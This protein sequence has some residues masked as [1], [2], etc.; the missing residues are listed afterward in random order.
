M[1]GP[2]LSEYDV[3]PMKLSFA[4]R[5][6]R[7]AL[8]VFCWGL[9][10]ALSLQ[11]ALI[12]RWLASDLEVLSDGGMVG[13]WTSSSG[14]RVANADLGRE[15]TLWHGVTPAGGSVVR[16]ADHRLYTAA[17][18]VG[19]L[20]AFS[21][22]IVF[23]AEGPGA[24]LG[25][26]W[27][28][29]SG[30]VDAEQAGYTADWGAVIDETGQ[31][32]FGI[33]DPDQ[34]AY[35]AD[36]ISLVDGEFHVAVF[37]WGGGTQTVYVDDRTPVSQTGSATFPRNNAGC[38]FGSLHTDLDG[39]R[40]SGELVEV[41]FYDSALT[42]PEAAA[43][44][45]Q[46]TATHIDA[47]L[48]FV[49]AF[50]AAPN[51][52]YV[53]SSATLSWNVANASGL[54][55]AP[56]VGTVSGPTGAVMVWPMTTT[57]YTLA[58]TNADGR[59]EATVTVTVDPGIPVAFG[60][61]TNTVENTTVAIT[62][63]GQDPNGDPLTYHLD[64][65]P[66]HGALLGT[67]PQITYA[68]AA[69][70]LGGDQLT[71]HVNDGRTDSSLAVV[72]VTVVEPPVA[73]TDMFLSAASIPAG[74]G[75]SEYV[76]TI[77]TVDV[78]LH[79]RHVYQLVPGARDNARFTVTSNQLWTAS[80]F[81]ATNG[82]S[83]TVRLRVTDSAALSLEKDFTLNVVG[84]SRDVVINEIHYNPADN[85]VRSEFIEF[86]NPNPEP[87]DMGG[88]RLRGGVDFNFPPGTQIA[89]HD[90]LVVAQD[91]LAISTV[92]GIAALG[93][94][95][96]SL[97]N[98]GEQIA[99]RDSG[100]RV[101]DQVDYRSEFPW[102]VAANGGGVSMELINPALDN[103]LGSSWSA[104]RSDTVTPT[105]L[106]TVFI[107][108]AD[109]YWHYRRGTNEP[110]S[111]ASAWRE[112]DFA[113]DATWTVGRTSIGYG[114]GDDNTVLSDMQNSYFCFFARHTFTLTEDPLPE[115]LVLRVYVDDGAILWING[116]EVA[117]PHVSS[118]DK[119]YNVGTGTTDHEAAW[120]TLTLANASAF[121]RPGENVLVA[122]V[123]NVTLGSSDVSFDLELKTPDVVIE[124]PQ[125]TPGQRNL[126]FQHNAAPNIRQVNH[127]PQSPRSTNDLFVT[128]K[129]T[130]PQGVGAVS[131]AY[132]S[133]AP[134]AFIPSVL[135]RSVTEMNNDPEGAPP[136]NPA[137][138]LGWMS[139]PMVDDGTGG[140]AVAG[141]DIF[142]G[143]IPAQPNRTLVRYRVTVTDRFGATRRAPFADDPSLNFAAF[144]YDGV[145]AYEGISAA[146]LETLPVYFFITRAQDLASCTAY[147]G[148]Q[149][150]QGSPAWFVFNW[151]CAV[152][153][154]GEVYDHVRYRLR[155]ANGR[156]QP[157]K[158][159]FRFKFNDGRHFAARDQ[160]GA[161]YPTKWSALETGKGQSNQQTLTFGLN[162][163]I[164]Y[165]LWNRVGVPAPFSHFFHWRVVDGAAEAPDRYGGDFWGLGWAQENYD[166]RFLEAHSLA[167]GNLYKLVNSTD[168]SLDQLRYQ[169]PDAV[170]DGSDHA[171]IYRNLNSSQTAAW[172]LAHV[173]YPLWYRYHA[174][175]EGVRNY[176]FWPGCDKN[177]AYYF[178]PIY[179]AQNDYYGRLWI[180]PWDVTDT[181][182]PTWNS[183]QDS[184][185]A[186]IFSGSTKPELIRDYRNTVREIRDLLFQRDQIEPILD[187]FAGTLARFVPADLIRW[188]NA[189]AS[190]GNYRSMARPGP[191][192]TA[193][194]TGYVQDLKNFLFV[195][196]THDW[197]T[198]RPT[199][200]AAGWV[201]RLDVVAADAATPSRPLVTYLGPSG[202]PVDQLT[203]SSSAFAD[204]QGTNT[205][206][207]MQWRV[208]QV[209]P[210]GTVVTNPAQLRLEW[211]A[212]WDSGPIADG[213]SN[214]TLP[215]TS[216]VPG[217]TYRVRVR[218]QDNTGRWSG[219]SA[220]IQFVPAAVDLVSDLRASLVFSEIMY[221][222]PPLGWIDSDELEFIELQN[223]GTRTLDLGGLFFSSGVTFSFPL[224]TALAPGKRFL[225]ARNPAALAQRYPGL[226]AQGVYTGKLNNSGETLAISHP[227]AGVI[228]SVTYA[229]L[230]PWP[231]TAD[232]F[233]FSLV[234]GDPLT[235]VYAAS[236]QLLGT[237]GT[238]GAACTIGGV[239]INEVL[240]SST[241][242]LA[243]AIE[244]QNL[245][246][247]PVDVTGWYLTD[248]PA[249]PW[250]YRIPATPALAPG[251]F[252]VVDER[253]F[254]PTPG[255][256]PSFS[257]SSFGDQVYLFSADASGNLTGYS[258]G[259]AFDG[260][261]D[262]VSYGRY[263]NSVGEEQLPLQ[264]ERTLG[265]ANAGPSL[266]PVVLSEIHYHP[267]MPEDEFVE[268]R[269]L[270]AQP[271]PL[272]DPTHPTNTWNV[273]GL[274]HTFPTNISIAPRGFL[275][276]VST[277]ANGF[278]ARF[279]VP[280]EVP[281][282]EYTGGLQNNGE[283][284]ALRAP[285]LPTTDGVPYFPVDRV[286]YSTNTPW[287]TSAAGLGDSLQR[288]DLTA[289]ADDPINWQAAAPTPG[290]PY[291]GGQPLMDFGIQLDADDA[292]P[293]L[294][295]FAEGDRTYT[296]QY[297]DSLESP[298]W[299]RLIDVPAQPSNRDEIHRDP[300]QRT[301]RFYRAVTPAVPEP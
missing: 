61:S 88:W 178:E 1:D 45:G 116:Q 165:F 155:G 271:V 17:S 122:Q 6:R 149:M 287:P 31:I 223:A 169:A 220:P 154:D 265:G 15:P 168:V 90:Y 245:A 158:R 12:D 67:P 80:S 16:F 131:L 201:A 121:L 113:E 197:W 99:L 109:P 186:S 22:A 195:G 299:H 170:T 47:A 55:I 130:D 56:D 213:S 222:P 20:E 115:T 107:P 241:P 174:I 218:H 261:K 256:H 215:P 231:V 120:E 171:N 37:T 24:N 243:D 106:S 225:L 298:V 208:A 73:P 187:A 3:R 202:Y 66:Q 97:D 301:T 283:R 30:I 54:S 226:A 128:A 249:D 92:F 221:H 194:L 180:L 117:R 18:P 228:L 75:P 118:G 87:V 35:L 284:L 83:L 86:Y 294:R 25:T 238:A 44:I 282:L 200:S 11:A 60:F 183:G 210:A 71:F 148:N 139:V 277:N 167:K 93:P 270:T 233:G 82:A 250:K 21:V 193:G 247:N 102:P 280:D 159:S 269:N 127:A 191:A 263:V 110:S 147:T 175:C 268:L 276:L 112:L 266:G 91:P 95:T 5:P 274:S 289:Y 184:A 126:S 10:A 104:P 292:K 7:I 142:T 240:T 140:D 164:S 205:F 278:R 46:L 52:I 219:W 34:T 196:G 29:K 297:A 163:T 101:V 234:L 258:H 267:P 207:A 27:Y 2:G 157:G 217:Q 300:A 253:Q 279:S 49:H 177:A 176:D 166:V 68:P 133:V 227:H 212:S 39:Q 257:L 94:W 41:Q 272:C 114:D 273:S 14:A 108:S 255:L 51:S 58:A 138:E 275:L 145:P 264:I 242:P 285:D 146:D 124:G 229:P 173:N 209:L 98:D 143:V 63:T 185:Y 36:G 78:N 188:S 153:Y 23:R 85:T 64:S 224:G 72:S 152:V 53:G 199:V 172:L 111:P 81:S 42:G 132:Q 252:L 77:R 8:A 203:F 135:P 48:P 74:T 79:D 125:P 69:G 192:L 296:I 288:L 119:T 182:G 19:G 129:V 291:P 214:I 281:I 4:G 232:G 239:V 70:Y 105:N 43:L 198:D 62:L 161:R 59:A 33:G 211:D 190:T 293:E 38:S 248:D 96:G 204:P 295:L 9:A 160:S 181:W 262:G 32:G 237:P 141:D 28:S 246:A 179:T 156:Y 236:A 103:D 235:G 50:T 134:G 150:V 189:P 123:I 13:T 206:A 89:A 100:D 26:Q 254:N 259:F 216:V 144:V 57:T 244:L 136:S 290:A 260:A 162:E 286:R 84:E 76:A 40:F 230:A 251:E 151:Q 137:F 65:Q